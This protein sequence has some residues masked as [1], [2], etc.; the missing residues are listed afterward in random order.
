MDEVLISDNR[1]MTDKFNLPKGF[2][3][4]DNPDHPFAYDGPDILLSD[5]SGLIAIFKVRPNEDTNPIKLISRLT[6]SLITYPAETQ[7]LLLIDGRIHNHIFSKFEKYYFNK[8]IEVNDLRKSKAILRDKKPDNIIK[9]IKQIQKRL[10]NSQAQIQNDNV[11]YAKKMMQQKKEFP[12]VEELKDKASYYDKFTQREIYS[13]ANIYK[14]KEFIIGTKKLSSSTSDIVELR[15]Y[16]EFS[17]NTDFSVDNGVPYFT[18][19]K[20]K[21]LNLNEIPRIKYDPIKPIRVAS[22]LGWYLASTNQISDLENRI[23]Q[24]YRNK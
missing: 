5:K 24:Y 7:M 2:I 8:L 16:Y 11:E 6:N 23:P 14:H 1:A 18:H 21:T 22:L 4:V 9:S 20:R 10:F 13:K 12:R 17:I 19:L 3:Q 15:P